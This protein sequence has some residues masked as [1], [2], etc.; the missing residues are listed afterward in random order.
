MKECPYC[1][2]SISWEVDFNR[3]N[4]PKSIRYAVLKR[5]YWKCNICSCKLKYSSNS[6]FEGA[7]AHIDHIEPF[8]NRKEG[9]SIHMLSNL[10]AL[11]PNCNLVKSDRTTRNVIK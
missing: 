7:V 2:S 3:R 11:C 4:I 1:G 5:Q 9:E 8:K 6:K 10:Q